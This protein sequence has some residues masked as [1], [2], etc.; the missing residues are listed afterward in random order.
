MRG[1]TARELFTANKH[2]DASKINRASTDVINAFWQL[3]LPRVWGGRQPGWDR[4][5]AARHVGRQPPRRDLDPVRGL[6]RDRGIPGAQRGKR[7][8]TTMPDPNRPP[9]PRPGG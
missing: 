7:R 3:D 5:N 4:R 8:S 9:A 6:R 1:V 2:A